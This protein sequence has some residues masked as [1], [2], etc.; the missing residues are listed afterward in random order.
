LAHVS[1]QALDD[2]YWCRIFGKVEGKSMVWKYGNP[3]RYPTDEFEQLK[4][5]I[6]T[7]FAAD[8]F[9]LNLKNSAPVDVAAALNISEAEK[10]K[11]KKLSQSMA[12]FF[13]G[14]LA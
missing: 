10:E 7:T 8:E 4:T 2:Y 12:D 6:L 13:K 14:P 1:A 9:K 5:I 11:A 3:W